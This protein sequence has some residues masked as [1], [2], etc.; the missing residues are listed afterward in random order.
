MVSGSRVPG[1]SIG[2]PSASLMLYGI[3]LA[4]TRDRSIRAHRQRN[5]AGRINSCGSTHNSAVDRIE[6]RRAKVVRDWGCQMQDFVRPRAQASGSL[7]SVGAILL[8]LLCIVGVD[9]AALAA[10]VLDG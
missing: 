6:V 7:C 1:G 3:G 9:R 8:A 5:A 4:P 10:I 2:P